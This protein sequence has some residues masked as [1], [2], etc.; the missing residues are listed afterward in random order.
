MR[1]SS[2]TVLSG[3]F[4]MEIEH[5]EFTLQANEGIKISSRQAHQA[6]NRSG[7][8]VRILVT[9]QPPSHGDRVAETTT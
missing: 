5:H 7:D 8:D 1:G 6:I 4:T 3:I 9:S 2:S